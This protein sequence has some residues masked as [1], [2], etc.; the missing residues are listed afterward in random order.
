M[1]FTMRFVDGPTLDLIPGGNQ[2]PV[3]PQNPNKYIDLSQFALPLTNCALDVRFDI[4]PSPCTANLLSGGKIASTGAFL[5]NLGRNILISP[6]VANADVTLIKETSL[7][8]LSESSKLQF[9][10]ELFNL[11][12][13]PNFGNPELTLYGRNGLIRSGAGRIASTRINARQMQ[14][15][16]RLAF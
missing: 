1:D 3:N 14:L 9:R 15:A 10:W 12:N 7:P 6:G 5:G 8:F 4:M 2:N 16:L 13:R 11:F